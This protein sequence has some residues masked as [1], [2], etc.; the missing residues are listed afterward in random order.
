MHDQ[1]DER[2]S[3]LSKKLLEGTITATERQELF[4]WLNRTEAQPL[5]IPADVA[6]SRQELKDR[7]LQ[8]LLMDMQTA[9]AETGAVVTLAA[10]KRSWIKYAAAAAV[11][12]IVSATALILSNRRQAKDHTP[13]LAQAIVPGSYKAILTL[14]DGTH[15]TLDSAGEGQLA[16]QGNATVLKNGDDQISYVLKGHTD[17]EVLMNTMTTPRGGRYQ[18]VLPDG[19]K[20]WLNAASSITYPAAFTGANRKVKIEGEAYFEVAKDKAH[21]FIVDVDGKQTVE[22]LGTHFNINSYADEDAIRTTLLEGK[23]KVSATQ[24]ETRNQKPETVLSPGQQATQQH[25]Q[26]AITSNVDISNVMA[27]KKGFLN[28]DHASIPTAMRRIERW[29]DVQVVYEG[30]VPADWLM[31]ELPLD[32]NITKVMSILERVGVRCRIEGKKIIV[33][34]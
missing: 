27:W 30:A 22:V 5:Q 23:V 21:P 19:T 4:D 20:V 12:I 15:I 17:S 9:P 33:S 31:G 29:Y 13:S 8:R 2:Y 1:Q 11:L 6:G 25:D 26:L 14:A 34:K 32:A 10:R 28:F 7:M 3:R 24:P 16:Q 18:L